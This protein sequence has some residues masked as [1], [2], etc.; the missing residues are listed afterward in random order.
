RL[1][2]PPDATLVTIQIRKNHPS[3]DCARTD[4]HWAKALSGG[5]HER[6]VPSRLPRGGNKTAPDIYSR[7]TGT[8]VGCEKAYSHSIPQ[9]QRCQK[10]SRRNE[11]CIGFSEDHARNLAPKAHCFA[12]ALKTTRSTLQP[13]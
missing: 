6:V 1:G 9:R 12:N 11:T 3:G 13:H 4:A 8:D 10:A 7:R 5:P 2:T